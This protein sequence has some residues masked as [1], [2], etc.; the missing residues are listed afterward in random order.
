MQNKCR[1]EKC[2]TSGFR[3][4]VVI[5]QFERKHSGVICLLM[6]QALV[7]MDH[8]LLGGPCCAVFTCPVSF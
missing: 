1:V 6:P 5:G 7:Q 3:Q 4:P 8:C 2:Q